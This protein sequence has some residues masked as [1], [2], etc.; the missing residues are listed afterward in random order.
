MSVE[1]R[2]VD[3]RKKLNEFVHFP[4]RLYAGNKYYVPQPNITQKELLTDKNPFLKHSEIRLFLAYQNNACAGRIAAIFNK[5]HLQVYRDDTGFF[6]FFDSVNHTEVSRALFKS[7]FE[8]LKSKGIRNVL[9]PANPTSNDSLG[10]L[11]S[12]YDKAPLIM[13]PYN[14]S[15]YHDLCKDIGFVP[16]EDLYAYRVKSEGL[17]TRI[18]DRLVQRLITRL[19]KSGIVFRHCS[20]KSFKQDMQQLRLAYNRSNADNY[21]FMPLNE[22]EF[23]FLA[24]GLKHI[25]PLDQ[26]LFAEKNGKIIGFLLAVPDINQMLKTIKSGKLFPFG[27]FKL[28]FGRNKIF[29]ARIMILG[30]LPEYRN[31]G[32][33]L[34]FFKEIQANLARKG[35]KSAEA[36][37]VLANNKNMNSAMRK[38]G[39]E[40]VKTYRLYRKEIEQ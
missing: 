8:Y 29:D 33:E 23:G 5:T 32:V 15:Y 11:Y 37:Y 36:G 26:V 14:F 19:R 12:G 1:I 38:I 39:A 28:I 2:L 3:N 25:V 35:I 22:E 40:R 17:D 7:A 6:G 4:H 24:S 18:S 16:E 10:F 27:I 21:G 13:M 31:R 20:K 34:V 30:V 9:G